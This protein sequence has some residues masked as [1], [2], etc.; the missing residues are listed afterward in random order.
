LYRLPVMFPGL[1]FHPGLV[2]EPLVHE[3]NVFAQFTRLM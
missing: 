3:T 1:T 2:P